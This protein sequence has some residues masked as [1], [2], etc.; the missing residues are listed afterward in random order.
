MSLR[1]TI[2]KYVG[3]LYSSR[4]GLQVYGTLHSPATQGEVDCA[5][6]HDGEDLMW[7]S[8]TAFQD[9]GLARIIINHE[10]ERLMTIIQPRLIILRIEDY[11]RLE[12]IIPDDRFALKSDWQRQD[13]YTLHVEGD[14]KVHLD[15]I[16]EAFRQL[17][18]GEHPELLLP[19]I[20][21]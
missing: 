16:A 2:T 21:H 6:I 5:D 9:K 8:V 12:P 7:G 15:R 20:V 17:K 18:E 4:D 10:S 3:D 1:D 11:D 19:Q 14:Y 13:P